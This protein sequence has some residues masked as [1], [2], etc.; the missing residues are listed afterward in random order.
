MSLL[1]K[2]PVQR[3]KKIL[4]DYDES[5][6]II[7]LETSARTAR[8]A[9]SSAVRAEVSRTIIFR[10]WSNSLRMFSTRF[11]GSL[12]NKVSIQLLIVS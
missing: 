8:E 1:D 12:F 3:V 2:E 5:Q 7:V 4:K 11:T 10:D 6:N 9:A